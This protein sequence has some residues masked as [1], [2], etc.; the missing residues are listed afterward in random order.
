M[1]SGSVIAAVMTKYGTLSAA[2]F[3]NSTLP[4]IWLDEAPQEGTTGAQ[5]RPPYVI[6]RDGGGEDQWDTEVNAV[7]PGTFTLEVYYSGTNALAN[8]DTAMNAILWN[9]A[10]PNLVQGIGFMTLDLTPPLY[11]LAYAVLPTTDQHSYAGIDYA[12]QRTYKLAHDFRA[13]YQTRGTG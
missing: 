6:I 2:N 1:A 9:G 8:C 11:G 10:N 12:G 7:T 3:P 5:Q 4:P 13:T